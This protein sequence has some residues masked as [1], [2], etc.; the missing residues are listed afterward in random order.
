MADAV[1]LVKEW[2]TENRGKNRVALA[3]Y[4]CEA[5]DLR[6]ARGQLRSG[7]TLKALRVLEARGH[8]RLPKA[9]DAG[10]KSGHGRPRRLGRPVAPPHEVPA[11]A[12][13]VQGLKLV[14]VRPEEVSL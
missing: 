11:R 10:G 8:W 5:L 12:E 6:D 7:G 14:E 1:T 9:K 4:V 3:R 2:L 13:Q